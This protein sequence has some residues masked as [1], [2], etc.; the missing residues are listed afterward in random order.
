MNPV[1]R[2]LLVPV[3]VLLAA[4]GCSG[5]S[6][7]MEDRPLQTMREADVVQLVKAYAD[8]TAATLGGRLENWSTVSM[9][10]QGAGGDL[11][12]DGRWTLSGHA[13]IR[14]PED[15]HAV[16]LRR[17]RDLWTGQGYRITEFRTFPPDNRQGRLIGSNPADGVSISLQSTTPPQAFAVLILTP[18][19]K[20][21]AGEHPAT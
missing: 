8:S 3:S 5:D 13:Q 1:G 7:K 15:R 12:T 19:Y 2:L 14:V 17:L 10:C 16:T 9:P 21:A 20:P 4:T 6:D 18:C 11:T